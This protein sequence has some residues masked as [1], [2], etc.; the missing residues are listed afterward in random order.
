MTEPRSTRRADTHATAPGRRSGGGRKIDLLVA[1]AVAL[2]AVATIALAA[3]GGGSD[4]SAGSLPPVSTALTSATLVCPAALHP[5]AEPVL[6]ARAPRVAGGPV[7]V[8]RPGAGGL[9]G[10]GSS[11]TATLDRPGRVG[12]AGTSVITASGAAAPGL[13]AGRREPDAAAACL[14]PAYDE[15]YVGIGASAVND[16]VMTLV[17]PDGGQAVVDIDLLG[18]NGPTEASALRGM[19]VPGHRAVTVDLGRKAPNRLTLAA[20][21]LVSRG[22]VGVS[23]EHRYDRLGGAPVVSDHLPELDE[24]STDGVLLGATV[25]G[26]ALMLANPGDEDAQATIRVVNGESVFTPTGT[27]PVVVPAQS[28][29]RVPLRTVVPKTA[30]SGMLGLVVQSDQPLFATSRGMVG[31]DLSVVGMSPTVTGP[32]AAIVPDGASRLV[33]AGALRTGVVNV[34][35]R[36]AAGRVLI[37]KAVPLTAQAGVSVVLPRSAAIVTLDPRNTSVA[38]SLVTST[39]SGGS[40]VPIRD[41]VATA[42][43]P[44]V[45]PE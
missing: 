13:V 14:T 28:L 18:P 20:H 32:T 12:G 23:V 17:N 15:W 9:L 2:P 43:V 29:V 3:V 16:S 25:T 36:N 27:K 33:L 30:L 1:L 24:P 21:V 42:S 5:H 37:Q 40:V 19:V 35:V 44:A 7:R 11:V 31:G 8:S 6:V 4:P 38:A 26:Q 39:R 41:T 45:V 10:A 34:T 22:R